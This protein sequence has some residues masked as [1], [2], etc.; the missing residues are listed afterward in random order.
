MAKPVQTLILTTVG[1]KSGKRYLNPLIY[2]ESN[3]A[4]VVIGSKGGSTND[5]GWYR[6]I[7][8]NGVAEVVF[9]AGKFPVS[10][11]TASGPERSALWTMMAEYFPS[12]ASMQAGATREFPVVVLERRSKS[13]D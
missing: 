8:A 12:Y 4:Y 1:R 7:L 9:L 11:R 3:G 2:G 10:V 13:K 6:N 5:P